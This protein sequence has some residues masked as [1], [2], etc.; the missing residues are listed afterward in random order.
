MRDLIAGD[1]YERR[2]PGCGPY[3]ECGKHR[4]W[5]PERRQALREA[6]RRRI[7]RQQEAIRIALGDPGPAARERAS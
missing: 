5:T 3:C 6:A 7:E 2:Q 1:G 4:Q